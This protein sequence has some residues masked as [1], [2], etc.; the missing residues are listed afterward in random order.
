MSTLYTTWQDCADPLDSDSPSILIPL[1][2]SASRMDLDPDIAVM[3]GPAEIP[4][5]ALQVFCLVESHISMLCTRSGLIVFNRTPQLWNTHPFPILDLRN[6]PFL[7]IYLHCCQSM[8][9]PLPC[10]QFV[11]TSFRHRWPTTL[12]LRSANLSRSNPNL[13]TAP[14]ISS[15]SGGGLSDSTSWGSVK[16]LRTSKRWSLFLAMWQLPIPS[17]NMITVFSILQHDSSPPN[18]CKMQLPIPSYNMMI[19]TLSRVW[20]RWHHGSD[21]RHCTVNNMVSP[22]PQ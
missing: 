22:I 16:S 14:R 2:Q 3:P 17:C 7:C 11:F 1:T 18:G 6:L 21:D 15:F 9:N 12:I 4:A 20:P 13:S 10:H 19:A 5:E 8:F